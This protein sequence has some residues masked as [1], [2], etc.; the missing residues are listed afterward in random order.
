MD[1][2][3]EPLFERLDQFVAELGEIQA[4]AERSEDHVIAFE[5]LERWKGRC[6][7][8]L[9]TAVS[10]TEARRFSEAGGVFARN[11][12]ENLLRN[13]N[14]FGSLLL[15]LREELEGDPGH[16]LAG[17]GSKVRPSV[18][19]PLS[20][21]A[22]FIGHGRSSLWSRVQIFLEHDHK[23]TVVSFESASRTGEH[24]VKVL[25]DFLDSASFAVLVLTGEDVTA[26]GTSRARQNV[27]H[28]A[29]LFQGRLGFN[30]AVLLVEEGIEEFSNIDGLQQIRFTGDGIQQT[31]YE[32]GRVLRR[33]GIVA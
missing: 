26:A 30:R 25:E 28:E 29:G 9:A 5:R 10:P 16:Y 13:T 23:L 8:W 1:G 27:V 33:E 24:I 4:A 21:K 2:S 22:V 18:L 3:L 17:P 6:A 14:A 20:T 19:R 7:A 31:F 11:P 32:L 12:L 15:V